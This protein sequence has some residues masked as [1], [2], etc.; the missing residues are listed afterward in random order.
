MKPTALALL[1]LCLLAATACSSV[2]THGMDTHN[3]TIPVYSQ[4]F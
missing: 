1:M 2:N 3:M 4:K